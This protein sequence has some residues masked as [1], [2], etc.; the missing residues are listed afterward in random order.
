MIRINIV[1]S[2]VI[3]SLEVKLRNKIKHA[4]LLCKGYEDTK[5]CKIAWKKIDD[6]KKQIKDAKQCEFDERQCREYDI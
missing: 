4:K 6:L 5:E 2:S 3:P 1:S